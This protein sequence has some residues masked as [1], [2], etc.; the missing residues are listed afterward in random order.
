[1]PVASWLGSSVP[2]VVS[3]PSGAVG[4]SPG[5]FSVLGSASSSVYG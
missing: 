4:S 1:M 5:S 3:P 2:A